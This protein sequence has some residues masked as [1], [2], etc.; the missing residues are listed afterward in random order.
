MSP[1]TRTALLVYGLVHLLVGGFAAGW[2]SDSGLLFSAPSPPLSWVSAG[3]FFALAAISGSSTQRWW[4]WL[5]TALILS[6][7]AL[8]ALGL[9][10]L[11]GWILNGVGVILV[12][13][14]WRGALP[15]G[16]RT[17]FAR[18][19]REALVACSSSSPIRDEDL[20]S[21]PEAVQRYLRF[22][23]VVGKPAIRNF[24]VEFDGEF[25][26]GL[27]KPW[28]R[29][30][31]EQ[32]SVIDPPTRLFFMRLSMFGLPLEG[33]HVYRRGEAS[34][35]ISLGQVKRLVHGVGPEMNRGETVT[36]FNDLCFLA[37]SSLVPSALPERSCIEWTEL[38]PHRVSARF[39][40]EGITIE[41]E[42]TFREDGA[43]V[44]FLSRDRYLSEDGKTYRSLPWST[45][46]HSFAEAE[47]RRMLGSGDAIWVLPEGEFP[48]GR[49]R[50]TRIAYDVEMDR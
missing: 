21:L 23:G 31:A 24:R 1:R 10:A 30:H 27:T 6:S 49:V 32:I 46:A 15:S 11:P 50:V 25:R 26:T 4:A 33:L 12:V 42:L 40:N 37:P 14:G 13:H 3:L 45:P 16:F 38:D 17:R 5:A 19:A 22:A 48:Y 18:E 34:M 29:F 28:A 43:L 20:A 9:R 2:I 7:L 41:A 35:D 44:G 39:T 36:Y 8:P 47:G